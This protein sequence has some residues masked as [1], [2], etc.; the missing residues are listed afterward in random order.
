MKTTKPSVK[1]SLLSNPEVD[2]KNLTIGTSKIAN[3]SWTRAEL[4]LEARRI[5]R[6]NK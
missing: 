2:T 6:E 5:A 3:P 4:H 1:R